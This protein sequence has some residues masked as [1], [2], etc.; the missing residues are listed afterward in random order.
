[1]ISLQDDPCK[2]MSPFQFPMTFQSNK[3]LHR[4]AEV[5]NDTQGPKE[6]HEEPTGDWCMQWPEYTVQLSLKM[7]Q[8]FFSAS[9]IIGTK[10]NRILEK[11]LFKKTVC[12]IPRLKYLPCNLSNTYPGNLNNID[13]SLNLWPC[14][15][16]QILSFLKIQ[17]LFPKFKKYEG[18]LYHPLRIIVGAGGRAEWLTL[19]AFAEDLS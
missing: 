6:Q 17:P 2:V 4:A 12:V 16:A 19:A 15:T 10:W 13:F 1:M 7:M 9:D 5:P 3:F 18:I 11:P 8:F 14:Q